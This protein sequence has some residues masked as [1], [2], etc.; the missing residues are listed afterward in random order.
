LNGAPAHL[1]WRQQIASGQRL[2]P[3]IYSVGPTFE[4]P[5]TSE[6][7]VAEVDRQ[8]DA[9]YD[10][11]KIYNQVSAAEYPALIA[12]A[13]RKSLVIIGHVPRESGFIAT[14]NAGQNIAHAE[15]YLYT[16]FNHDPDPVHDLTHS[17]DAREIPQA[18]VLSKEAG[19]SVVATLV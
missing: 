19:I 2:G 11:V 8:A 14:L 10:G 1:H 13:K 17:L 3:T 7:A 12:E 6:E 4:R 18:V 16:F 5:R 9:G 15:E